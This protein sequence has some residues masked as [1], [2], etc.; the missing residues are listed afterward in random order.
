MGVKPDCYLIARQRFCRKPEILQGGAKIAAGT[1]LRRVNA[2]G[3]RNQAD[4]K[5]SLTELARDDAQQ[6]Q[7]IELVWREFKHLPVQN[8]CRL[9]LALLVQA[10][11]FFQ[12]GAD[13]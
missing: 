6:M 12:E 4:G 8:L 13:V 11:S 2:D 5:F 7:G 3:M 10:D 1:G 9:Q